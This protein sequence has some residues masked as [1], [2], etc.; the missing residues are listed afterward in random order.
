MLPSASIGT[1]PAGSKASRSQTTTVTHAAVAAADDF[2]GGQGHHGTHTGLA[3]GDQAPVPANAEPVSRGTAPV[4]DQAPPAANGAAT[5]TVLS[6]LADDFPGGQRP[7]DAQALPAAGEQCPPDPPLAF[8]VL[9]PWPEKPNRDLAAAADTLHDIE[10][11]RTASENR[12]R[13]FVRGTDKEDKDGG[14]RGYGWD[15][16]SPAVVAMATLVASMLCDSDVI[17]PILGKAPKRKGCCLEH[18]AERNLNRALRV[19]PLGPWVKAQKGVGEKQG[20]RLVGV[21]GDPYMRPALKLPDGSWDPERPRI[22]AEL[23][24]WCGYGEDKTRRGHIQRRKRRKPGEPAAPAANWNHAAKMRAY[25]VAVS[26]MK[27]GLD[28]R[29][30][31]KRAEGDDFATHTQECQCSPYRIV[32][33]RERIRYADAVHDEEC[34]QCGPAGHPA[35]PGSPLSLSHKKQRA[36]RRAAKEIIDDLWREARR[37][38]LETPVSGQCPVGTQGTL[39]ADGD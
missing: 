14:K 36:L 27:S 29:G 17:V 23:R 12:L 8:P 1:A 34:P 30:G 5:P 37:I 20:G 7:G 32:Y 28:K 26:C 18:D 21:I 10:R 35:Q 16:R 13:Q 19:H 3:A 6:L 31:C 22:L 38:H 9:S 39:A 24:S 11:L 15:L 33:D 25:L 2:P 4:R